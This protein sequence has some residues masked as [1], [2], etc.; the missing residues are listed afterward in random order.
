MKSMYLTSHFFKRVYCW[1]QEFTERCESSSSSCSFSRSLN[2]S[3]EL[4]MVLGFL[5]FTPAKPP[6]PKSPPQEHV[7]LSE[8]SQ[9]PEVCLSAS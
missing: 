8:F 4:R 7:Y 1:K 9:Q 2:I 5:N 3:Q 6:R